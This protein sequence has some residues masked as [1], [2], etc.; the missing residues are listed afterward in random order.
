MFYSA[1]RNF[2]KIRCEFHT[3]GYLVFW[4][5]YPVAKC[6]DTA[7]W[8]EYFNMA[9]FST[10]C[11]FVT[12]A[13]ARKKPTNRYLQLI[14]FSRRFRAIKIYDQFFNQYIHLTISYVRNLL[15]IYNTLQHIFNGKIYIFNDTAHLVSHLTFVE[16]TLLVAWQLM[17][18]FITCDLD[19]LTS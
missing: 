8:N 11:Q 4:K 18:K 5:P 9:S 6:V 12:C 19:F 13:S 17:K 16:Q 1:G 7:Y 3:T 14:Y 15:P 10:R 2:G